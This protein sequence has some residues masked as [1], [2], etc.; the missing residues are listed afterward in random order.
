MAE[1]IGQVRIIIH[2]QAILRIN[3]GPVLNHVQ[4]IARDT[5]K[6]ARVLSP[7]RTGRLASAWGYSPGGSNADGAFANVRLF[8]SV[9]PYAKYVLFGT[10]GPIVPT[11][12]RYLAVHNPTRTN[13]VAY[14]KWVRGQGANNFAQ[15]A[16]EMAMR[17]NGH[18]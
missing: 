9:A 16:V 11:R 17:E 7:K 14:R 1:R 2:E 13:V 8:R 5:V 4:K 15:R 3:T 12:S 10:T 6:Y 18:W